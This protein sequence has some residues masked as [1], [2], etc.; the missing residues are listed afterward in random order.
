MGLLDDLSNVQKNPYDC[1]AGRLLREL[2]PKE[3]AALLE[4]IDDVNTALPDL[5]KLLAKHGHIVSRK[6]LM[7]HRKRGTPA[8]G[9][10]CE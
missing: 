4:A 9:C 1:R 2:P 6:T 8:I 3:S 7:R 10:V 5:E